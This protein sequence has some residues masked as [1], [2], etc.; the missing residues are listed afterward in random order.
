MPQV[1]EFTV[2]A[3]ALGIGD[4]IGVDVDLGAGVFQT[5]KF[6]AFKLTR[7]GNT[8][9]VDSVNGDDST[10]TRGRSDKPFLTLTAAKTAASAG[11]TIVVGPGTYNET[12]LLKQSVSW[13][14]STGAVVQYTGSGGAIFDD[15]GIAIVSRIYG[16]GEFYQLGS[17]SNRV[18]FSLTNSS[19]I[20]ATFQEGFGTDGFAVVN[21]G[22]GGGASLQLVGI[23]SIGNLS[24]VAGTIIAQSPS[25]G[26]LSNTGGTLRIA[27]AGNVGSVTVSSAAVLT[28]IRCAGAG[29]VSLAK[30]S[31]MDV[32]GNITSLSVTGA[33]CNV[34][35]FDIGSTVSVAGSASGQAVLNLYFNNIFGTTTIDGTT[36]FAA[37]HFYG[38]F[39]NRLVVTQFALFY[40]DVSQIGSLYSDS[41]G[42]ST[43]INGAKITNASQVSGSLAPVE[44]NGSN[45]VRLQDCV[46]VSNGT[47]AF[48]VH[49]NTGGGDIVK[50]YGG[51][52]GNYTTDSVQ[53]TVGTL[54][55]DI[56]VD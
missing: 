5:Q 51:T 14:F 39:I 50:F 37:A 10:G 40:G 24:V 54:V 52:V 20:F 23:R 48:S 3:S 42:A 15:G 22:F 44:I 2:E 43:H 13:Y 9:F 30:D 55:V 21:D 53:V 41:G 31:A 25:I 8:V 46:L 27:S 18:I 16:Y 1:H 6:K 47:P 33:T 19:L 12:D 38:Q 28:S 49:G 56:D 29:V 4:F 7:S 36:D 11:D 34:R 32:S 26:N 35:C 17:G 45:T